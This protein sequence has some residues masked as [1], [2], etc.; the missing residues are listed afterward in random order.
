MINFM[1]QRLIS[2]LAATK[3]TNEQLFLIGTC[4]V[5]FGV[6]SIIGI[7]WLACVS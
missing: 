7:I 3:I 6:T 2:Q 1:R 4:M 5:M